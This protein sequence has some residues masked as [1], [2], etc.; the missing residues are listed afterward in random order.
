MTRVRQGIA[1]GIDIGGTTTTA[2][3]ADV[4][5]GAVLGRASGR[6]TAQAGGAAMLHLGVDL[7]D[8]ATALAGATPVAVGVGAAGVVD[9]QARRVVSAS[10]T[11]TDWAGYDVGTH[12]DRELGR[13]SALIN[14]VNAFLLAEMTWGAGR[15]SPDAVGLTLGT[16]VGGA[17]WLDGALWDGPT[18]AAGE[19][20]HFAPF[21]IEPYGPE[22]CSCGQRGH[23]E[24]I[25]SGAALVRRYATRSPNGRPTHC[26]TVARADLD[27]AAVAG[28]ARAG[29]PIAQAVFEEAGWALGQLAVTLAAV[30]DVQLS[31]VGGGVAASWDLMAP[32]FDAYIAAHPVVSGAVPSIAT[33]QLGPDAVALGAALAAATA[34]STPT[35]SV[36][37]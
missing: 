34:A 3:V 7:L 4:A 1:A 6:T 36:T 11:F 25:A 35:G 15:G 29:D 8:T 31:L 9:A 28:R 19:L 37:S 14:D 10:Q 20:G 26:L 16:G 2:V 5:T 23:L 13:P 27:A 30:L 33:G 32:G 24:S 21:I 18:G 17:L 22:P 12:L